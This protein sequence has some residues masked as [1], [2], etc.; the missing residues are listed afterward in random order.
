MENII[1]IIAAL[2]IIVFIIEIVYDFYKG[3]YKK[4]EFGNL[5]SMIK[6]Y[7]DGSQKENRPQEYPKIIKLIKTY[8]Y[9]LVI[10]AVI[11]FILIEYINK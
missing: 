5:K 8:K 10:I 6:R 2:T 4:G 11:L 9:L 1:S 7:F 3:E